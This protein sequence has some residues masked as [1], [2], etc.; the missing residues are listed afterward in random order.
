MKFSIQCMA[1][2]G[3]PTSRQARIAE[4]DALFAMHAI[5]RQGVLQTHNFPHW[6][7]IE[8]RMEAKEQ[9]QQ[10]AMLAAA[11]VGGKGQGGQGQPRGP[12]TGH[13]H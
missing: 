2:S 3:N 8:Q 12:G 9:A 1:G 11:S 13:P 5:D 6:Q 10:A 4:A 7:N